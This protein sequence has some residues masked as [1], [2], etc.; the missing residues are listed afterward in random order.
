MYAAIP[1][2]INGALFLGFGGVGSFGGVFWPALSTM[3]LVI[4]LNEDYCIE[5]KFKCERYIARVNENCDCH[6]GSTVRTSPGVE[7]RRIKRN[8]NFSKKEEISKSKKFTL[9]SAALQL[10]KNPLAQ[11]FELQDVIEGEQVREGL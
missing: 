1:A 11:F 4:C 5:D 3:R 9:T 8:V 6:Y 7:T 2:S 10:A